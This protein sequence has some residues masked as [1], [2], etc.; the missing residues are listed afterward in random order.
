VVVTV[1]DFLRD[2]DEV[3]DLVFPDEL[4]PLLSMM[5][6]AKDADFFRASLLA[7]AVDLLEAA[8]CP[9]GES[10]VD[11]PAEADAEGEPDPDA[12]GLF[13]HVFRAALPRTSSASSAADFFFDL[14]SS[15]D[16]LDDM[17]VSRVP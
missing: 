3:L 9:A 11:A 16:R 4:R 1:A 2:E 8:C 15:D 10:P 13:S 7:S 12:L 14:S 6:V 17:I 5:A